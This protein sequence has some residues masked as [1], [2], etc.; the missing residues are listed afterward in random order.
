MSLLVSHSVFSSSSESTQKENSGTQDRHREAQV[1]QV[2]DMDRFELATVGSDTNPVYTQCI[3]DY[4]W[5]RLCTYT[6]TTK[7]F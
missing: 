4:F 7:I 5:N 6:F 1:S 2:D 3:Q